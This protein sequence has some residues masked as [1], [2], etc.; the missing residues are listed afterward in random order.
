MLTRPDRVDV[1]KSEAKAEVE[2]Y[3]YEAE[4]KSLTFQHQHYVSHITTVQTSSL[5]IRNTSSSSTL[6]LILPPFGRIISP[7]WLKTLST[8][9]EMA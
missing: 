6:S 7:L 5:H 2:A 4:A 9:I 8:K 3:A 1:A